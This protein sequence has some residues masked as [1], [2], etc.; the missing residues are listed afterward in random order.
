MKLYG[1]LTIITFV[2][3]FI[4]IYLHNCIVY[5][6]FA[7]DLRL[8]HNCD[9]NFIWDMRGRYVLYKIFE[10]YER[11][12]KREGEG[13]REIVRERKRGIEKGRQ[14]DLFRNN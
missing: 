3:Y 13:N 2:N 7:C 9:H 11:Q 12:R 14:L 4:I 6:L 10:D 1:G 8:L 5:V